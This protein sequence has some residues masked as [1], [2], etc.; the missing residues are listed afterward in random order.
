MGSYE[1]GQAKVGDYAVVGKQLLGHVDNSSYPDVQV[2][3]QMTLVVPADAKGP[4]P[5][6]MMFGG[7]SYPRWRFP[8]L[9]SRDAA[10]RR[11]RGRGPIAPPAN[12]DP[13]ATEQLIADGWGFASDQPGQHSGG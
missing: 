5:V 10:E 4:V 6:M 9:Y 13:P 1:D 2:D 3:I 12:A 11:A 7:R 8:R